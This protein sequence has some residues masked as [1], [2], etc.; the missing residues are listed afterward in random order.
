[1]AGF[2]AVHTGAGNCI[3]EAKYQ[4]V[5][6]E[7]CIRATEILRNG[8][9]ALDACEAA[10]IRLE[11]CGNTNAGFG[12]NLCLDGTVSCDA[13]IMSG[14]TLNFGA[15]T[16]VSRVQN[17]IA[18]ARCIC[19]GQSQTQP[20]ERIPPM[21]LA[22]S[23]AERYAEEVGCTMIDPAVMISSKAKFHYNHYKAKYDLAIDNSRNKA[24][25]ATAADVPDPGN[26]VELATALDTVG[27]VCVDGAG[28][29]AAGC[30]SGGILLKM[31][32]RVGQAATYGAG[33]WATDTDELSV[34]TCTTGNG[35]YLM[36]TLLAREICND[37]FSS[38]CAV[39]SL[40]NTFQQKFLDSPLLPQQHEHYA[41][42]L[43]LLY[44]PK[45]SAGEVMWSHT[46]Q[47]FCVGYMA[48][49]Q[50]VPKFVHSPLPTYNVAGKSCIV[51]GHTFHLRI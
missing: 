14:A 49:T 48:T 41:G 10:I 40:H 27:A 23:G 35:E 39:T 38:D 18:L 9:N 44:Y 19:E 37:A 12:S 8:G 43:T 2:V 34:A 16:N 36:K 21:V 50:K 6:K 46:T 20:L 17:P 32:G 29:T 3:D 11:N 15:C 33:C 47:S 30:S 24:D 7:S 45:S 26:E 22:G 4:R 13:S 5:I 28:N 51:N 25:D 1:M 42:A 31:P